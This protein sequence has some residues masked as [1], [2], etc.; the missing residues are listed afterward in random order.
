MGFRTGGSRFL[1]GNLTL[2]EMLEERLASF[3]EKKAIVFVSGFSTNLGAIAAL[4]TPQDIILCDRE[5][6]ASIL[7]GYPI[8]RARMM[9]FAHNDALAASKP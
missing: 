7:S 8:L 9:P 4:V 3:V 1:C 2:H 5:N 6:H